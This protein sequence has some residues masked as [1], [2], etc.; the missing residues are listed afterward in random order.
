MN[1]TQNPFDTNKCKIFIPFI[2]TL[3][4]SI[5]IVIAFFLPYKSATEDYRE[6]LENNPNE[7]YAEE[8]GMTNKSAIDISLLE[9]ARMYG[10]IAAETEV[11][12]IL[13]IVVLSIICIIA[14]LSILTLLF[15]AKKKPI[16][17]II[18]N[19]LNFAVFRLLCYD[20][21][22]RGVNV[23]NYDWGISYYVYHIFPLLILAGSIWLLVNKIHLKKESR[24]TQSPTGN[25]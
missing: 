24:K 10:Y 23:R 22:D 20:F 5:I 12:Q 17:T 7:M 3:I 11:F 6:Y 19:L 1:K 14:V 21:E 25:E 13:G 16:A 2:I 15:T 9:Y 4:S 8:I 18:F